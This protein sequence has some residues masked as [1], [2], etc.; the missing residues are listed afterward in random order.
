MHGRRHPLLTEPQHLAARWISSVLMQATFFAPW[1]PDHFGDLLGLRVLTWV[2]AASWADLAYGRIGTGLMNLGFFVGFLCLF[3]YGLV[4]ITLAM[5][6]R[7][8]PPHWIQAQALPA[9]LA[10][11]AAAPM[12]G[13][14][15]S[16]FEVAN[17][18]WGYW[19]MW[20]AVLLAG[21]VE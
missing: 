14:M 7:R 2:S 11:G 3:L 18:L 10:A 4:S 15:F 19:T 1:I 8:Q 17:F 16:G 13:F 6:R 12:G 21:V 9:M 20:V 5:T